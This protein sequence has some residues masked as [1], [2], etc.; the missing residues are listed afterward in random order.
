MLVVMTYVMMYMEVRT[1]VMV[2]VTCKLMETITGHALLERHRANRARRMA[3][4]VA[5]WRI[6]R[7]TDLSVMDMSNKPGVTET[8]QPMRV[9]FRE[10]HAVR[11]GQT[12]TV[13]EKERALLR[14]G[15]EREGVGPLVAKESRP[16]TQPIVSLLPARGHGVRRKLARQ[17]PP[18][19]QRPPLPVTPR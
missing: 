3:V 16:K 5:P 8:L 17:R 7:I 11:E 9:R 18:F 15:S 12:P 4:Y 1:I 13:K 19:L 10:G 6:F 14:R 2:P